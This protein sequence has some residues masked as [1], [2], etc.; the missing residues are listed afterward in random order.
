MP[1]YARFVGYD[2]DQFDDD[3]GSVYDVGEVGA[4]RGRAR[5]SYR[6]GGRQ[7]S[8][9]A[10]VRGGG[11]GQ[12]PL[13]PSPQRFQAMPL[14]SITLAASASGNLVAR[15]QRE[16]QGNRLSLTA[17]TAA[18]AI[19]NAI[20]VTD[21]KVGTVSQFAGNTSLPADIFFNNATG[22]VMEMTPAPGG[23]D[24]TLF[25]TNTDAVN[26]VTVSGAIIGKTRGN[27]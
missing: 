7:G 15:V 16:I 3:V 1:P 25:L 21:L 2:D 5:R 10:A 14:G 22:I 6:R 19:S 27:A 18:G 11:R 9:R 23:I 26:A 13:Q 4:R 20:L 17:L 8:R 12:P 24:I